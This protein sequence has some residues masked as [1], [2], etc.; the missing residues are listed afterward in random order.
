MWLDQGRIYYRTDCLR[1]LALD[2]SDEKRIADV[3][4][5]AVCCV[6][7]GVAYCSS[8]GGRT[9]TAYD[10]D[11]GTSK[12]VFDSDW[13]KGPLVVKAI[14]PDGNRIYFGV[15]EETTRAPNKIDGYMS[16]DLNGSD[17]RDESGFPA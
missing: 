16:V 17:L 10:T 14:V 7:D 2:G 4:A 5:Y 6:A 13:T 8:N 1:S 12:K 3:D 11:S 9:V 15:A